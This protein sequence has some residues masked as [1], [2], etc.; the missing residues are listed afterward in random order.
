[1]TDDDAAEFRRRQTGLRLE[2][3]AGAGHA[4]QSDQPLELTRLIE[5]FVFG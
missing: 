3:V 2:V 1:M 4:V 5:D